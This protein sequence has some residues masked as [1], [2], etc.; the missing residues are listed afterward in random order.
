MEIAAYVLCKLPWPSILNQEYQTMGCETRKIMNIS[1]ILMYLMQTQNNNYHK[2][3]IIRS[4]KCAKASFS[5][6]SIA[7]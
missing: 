7:V 5:G 1:M 4:T 6:T 2:N 3:T